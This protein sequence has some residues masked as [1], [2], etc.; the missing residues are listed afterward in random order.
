MIWASCL[1]AR[2]TRG[3]DDATLAEPAERPFRLE[4]PVW[5]CVGLLRP[6]TIPRGSLL[7]HV[8][9]LFVQFLSS[10]AVAGGGL[11]FASS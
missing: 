9:L 7:G 4:V 3:L 8:I 5:D 6:Y 11:E 2:T 1:D 10:G